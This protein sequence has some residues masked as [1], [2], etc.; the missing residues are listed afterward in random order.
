METEIGVS[1]QRA[2]L[3]DVKMINIKVINVDQ[4]EIKT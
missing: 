2:S 3:E 1:H 4:Q